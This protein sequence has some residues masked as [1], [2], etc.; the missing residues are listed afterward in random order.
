[1]LGEKSKSREVALKVL[2]MNPANNQAYSILIQTGSDEDIEK[3][4]H[5]MKENQDVAYALGFHFYQ[6]GN[7]DEAKKWLEISIENETENI[8]EI[9]PLLAFVL[10][11]KVILDTKTIPGFQ[12][13]LTHKEEIEKAIELL[14]FSWKSIPDK[15][16]RLLHVDWVINRAIAKR[17]LNNIEGAEA[18]IN[19]A[20]EL[21]SSDIKALHFK[22]LVEFEKG[23]FEKVISLFQGEISTEFEVGS[24][25]LYFEA[26]NK[27]GKST[28]TIIKLNE[29]LKQNPQFEGKELLEQLLFYSYIGLCRYD[30]ARELAELR[31]K[32]DPENV[33]KIVELSQV[34]RTVGEKDSSISLLKKVK[35]N[36][37]DVSNVTDLKAVADE[38]FRVELF[39]DACEVYGHFVDTTQVT[40]LTHKMVEA[41]YRSGNIGRSLEICKSLRRKFGPIVHITQLEIAIYHEINDLEKERNALTQY[42]GCFPED[43]GMKLNLALLNRRCNNYDKVDEFLRTPFDM[44]CL[45]LEGCICLAFLFSERGFFQKAVEILYE[46]R[47]S[48]FDNEKVHSSYIKLISFNEAEENQKWIH[49]TEVGLDS[50]ILI[51]D[52][53]GKKQNYIIE[54]RRD[55]DIQKR[56]LKPE[57]DLAKRLL[58]KREGDKV[59]FET[60]VSEEVFKIKEL[61]SKYIQ[62]FQ[63][64]INIFNKLFPNSR[65]LFQISISKKGKDEISTEGLEKITEMARLKYENNEKMKLMYVKEQRP[66]GNVSNIFGMNIF[67]LWFYFTMDSSLG[68]YCSTGYYEIKEALSCFKKELR[69]VVDPLSTLTIVTLG[70]GNIIKNYFGKLGIS[71]STIDLFQEILI[72]KN[73]TNSKDHCILGYLNGNFFI[74]EV[75]AEYEQ[76]IAGKLK[77]VLEW[78]QIN[79][80]V[81][82]CNKALSINREKR[83]E[84]D[85]M[86]GRA[87]TDTI[88]IA[89]EEGNI[90]YSEEKI[91]RDVARLEFNTDGVW[92]Q[93]LLVYL[94]ENG[95]VEKHQYNQKTIELVN[96][97]YHHTSINS[98]ILLDAAKQ[99]E[100][101]LTSPFINVLKILEGKNCDEGS[102][103][104]L[105]INFISLIL[106]EQISIDDFYVLF[107]NTI[108]A[109]VK[110]RWAPSIISKLK[111]MVMYRFDL[112]SFENRIEIFELIEI[113]Q[114][115]YYTYSANHNEW[116]EPIFNKD[117]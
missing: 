72:E 91:I 100:W 19:F 47:R 110:G 109:V 74:Q 90:L 70:I 26:L 97:N 2:E 84:L 25:I 73:S 28:Y 43:Y 49:P 86:I 32:E 94:L 24:L 104:K 115:I 22:A 10:I 76:K 65:E 81:L 93:S 58:G 79:C 80:E 105:T 103:L 56:E 57:S 48:N 40:E 21:D 116:D 38:L 102:A 68:I 69:L 75:N 15:N 50:A 46:L 92:T 111:T 106:R 12:L 41:C 112:F 61:K 66:V 78:I 98:E 87:F 8:L 29:F 82:P 60:P 31:L 13:C 36:V 14:T 44:N 59:V 37:S 55:A 101:K 42:L 67:D 64:S 108:S 107:M 95:L 63:E 27:I 77:S 18:D 71:Q 52:P 117:S 1:M 51:E 7:L 9:R 85:S 30:E 83:T 3:I 88:L 54:G 45:S 34:M 39:E 33:T 11:E 89:S 114:V 16:L 4:P 23:N 62:A 20:Y 5:Y 6:K 35:D 99:A 17:L 53:Y 96:L 113:W